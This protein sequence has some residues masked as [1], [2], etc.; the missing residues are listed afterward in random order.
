MKTAAT[1]RPLT[2]FPAPELV[3]AALE[4]EARLRDFARA[5]ATRRRGA[6]ADVD[7]FVRALA[8]YHATWTLCSRTA[9]PAL[10]ESALRIAV[11]AYCA[12]TGGAKR[13]AA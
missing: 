3:P 1:R 11:A 2:L 10:D 13:P 9:V 8:A 7:R 6:P 12:A 4:F 5:S